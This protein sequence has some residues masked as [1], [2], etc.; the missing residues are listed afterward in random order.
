MFELVID[1]ETLFYKIEYKRIKRIYIRFKHDHYLVT[2]PLFTTK[3]YIEKL[4]IESKDSL[5]KLKTKKPLIKL[6]LNQGSEIS[7]IGKKYIIMHG[8]K[9][10]LLDGVIY[11]K[12]TD[13]KSS[14]NRLSAKLLE[15]YVKDRIIYFHN[16]MYQ[17]NRYP[18][19]IIKNVKSKLGHYHL[20]K[21]QIM[22]GLGMV[23]NSNELIDYV[24]VHELAHIQEFNHQP[25]FYSLISKILPNYKDLE[26][27]LKMQ[28][29]V[30]WKL[31]L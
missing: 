2:A 1:S 15:N 24:I 19:V 29:E 31:F 14:L 11:L 4:L 3:K 9:E 21:H 27:T 6:D 16:L 7:L 8:L 12:T 23:Y 26:K 17:D 20:A 30:L 18:T 10:L 5:S 25:N 22:I 13:L 28:G